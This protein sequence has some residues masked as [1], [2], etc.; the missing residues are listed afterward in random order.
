MK[1]LLFVVVLGAASASACKDTGTNF[2]FD[3]APDSGSGDGGGKTDG[4][5]AG[6]DRPQATD[7]AADAPVDGE[8]N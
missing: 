2:T 3:A 8:G 4:G 1:R 5:D 7:T 6:A